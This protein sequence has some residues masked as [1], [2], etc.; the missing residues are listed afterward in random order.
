VR[1]WNIP[2]E[3]EYLTRKK[4]VCKKAGKRR[5]SDMLQCE[6]VAFSLT[7][8]LNCLPNAPEV[9]NFLLMTSHVFLKIWDNGFATVWALA[10]QLLFFKSGE[11]GGAV[12]KSLLASWL[13]SYRETRQIRRI[14]VMSLAIS[15][16]ALW[17]WERACHVNYESTL[18][19]IRILVSLKSRA[20][21]LYMFIS[22]SP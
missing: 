11:G 22:R 16:A 9:F 8:N 15:W 13:T 18:R 12:I 1:P 21:V 2:T 20:V 3:Q 4:R 14:S 19:A 6:R 7:A 5:Y 10:S 17:Q